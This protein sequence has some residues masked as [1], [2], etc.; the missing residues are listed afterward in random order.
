M[1]VTA[2][3]AQD[4]PHNQERPVRNLSSAQT[5][6]PCLDHIVNDCEQTDREFPLSSGAQKV[7]KGHIP[8]FG[9]QTSTFPVFTAGIDPTAVRAVRPHGHQSVKAES[10]VCFGLVVNHDM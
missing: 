6:N 10:T 2:C 7:W 4:G 9:K 1:L 5:E 8:S 3:N